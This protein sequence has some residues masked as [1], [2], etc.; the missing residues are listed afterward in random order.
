MIFQ[1]LEF[2]SSQNY[3]QETAKKSTDGRFVKIFMVQNQNQDVIGSELTESCNQLNYV[4]ME[5]T[6]LG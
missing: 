5:I 2:E 1:K 3:E 6:Y 4:F